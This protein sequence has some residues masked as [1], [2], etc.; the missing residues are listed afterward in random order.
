MDIRSF[1]NKAPQSKGKKSQKKS[2]KNGAGPASASSKNVEI[3][4]AA[5]DNHQKTT[6][7]P[8]QKKFDISPEEFFSQSNTSGS[9][10]KKRKKSEK[11]TKSTPKNA[12]VETKTTPAPDLTTCVKDDDE[13]NSSSRAAKSKKAERILSGRKTKLR[14]VILDDDSSDGADEDDEKQMDVDAYDTY[15]RTKVTSKTLEKPEKVVKQITENDGDRQT[16]LSQTNSISVVETVPEEGNKSVNDPTDS[17][18]ELHKP[19]KPLYLTGKT[20]V[21]TGVIEE[22]SREKLQEYILT[23]GGRC[24]SAVSGKTNYLV[25]GDLLEDNRPFK[26]GSKYRA[27]KEKGTPIILGLS[28]FNALAKKLE[29]SAAAP[30]DKPANYTAK[31]KANTYAKK[32]NPYAKANSNPYAKKSNPYAKSSN[33]NIAASPT[34]SLPAIAKIDT[35]GMLWADAHAPQTTRD[36][37]GNAEAVKKLTS[38]LNRWEQNN[39]GSKKHNGPKAA[40]LSGPPGIGKTTTATLVC[41]ESGRDALELNASDTRSKSSLK[42]MLGDVIGT[43]VL[44]FTSKNTKKGKYKKSAVKRCIIMDEVDGMGAGD[45]SGM[46]ELI[47]MIKG[48]KVPI[49]CICNDRQSQKLKSLIPHCLDLKYRRPVKSVIARRAVQISA[50]HLLP[51]EIN[52]AEALAESCGNDIRQVLNALQMWASGDKGKM[53]YAEYS[54]QKNAINKDESLRIGLFDAA[55][56]IVEG[57]RKDGSFFSRYD[58]Y[59]IDYS[60]MGLMVHQ[61]YLKVMTP[62]YLRARGAKSE[63]EEEEII[64]RMSAAADCMGDFDLV[65]G[66]LRAGQAWSLLP[67]CASLCVRT[68][69]L[70]GGTTGGMLQG[71][72]EFTSYLGK[73]SSRNKKQR[74]L[75]ELKHHLNFR[76]SSTSSE[77]RMMYLPAL[78]SHF[79]RMLVNNTSEAISEMDVYGLN[80]DDLFENIDEF[81]LPTSSGEKPK[82]FADMDSKTKAAFTREYNKG[83]HKSQALVAEQGASKKRKAPAI[84][85]RESDEEGDGDFDNDEDQK[86]EEDEKKIQELFS[87]KKG[88]GAGKSGSASKKKAKNRGKR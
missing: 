77:L 48:S 88:R 43:Q 76:I 71:F 1:F 41:K 35:K 84:E 65:E 66:R 54:K 45:R 29:E 27:A 6:R 75:G 60:F 22:V 51:V 34:S 78:H 79:Y 15:P 81:S 11:E 82:K 4:T 26:S 87:K 85:Q 13:M 52:A 38:W 14:K 23:N 8:T 72:P 9:V 28:E 70:A 33:S 80:R 59:F 3:D 64:S 12:P 10:S 69:S 30:D 55:K 74:L 58:A 68:G 53:T 36:I 49:I 32:A 25:A 20:F 50:Q 67:T 40:L 62:Q 24:T 31:P 39:L 61:N 2:I 56:S 44:S 57:M 73:N 17:A 21:F 37:L 83:I 18:S 16:E 42:E 46:S 7:L 86:E 5:S 19:E 47:Q 63:L